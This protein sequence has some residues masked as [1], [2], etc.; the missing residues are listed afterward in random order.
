MG[1]VSLD[2][3]TAPVF[4]ARGAGGASGAVR[5]VAVG[6]SVPVVVQKVGA[7]AFSNPGRGA[8]LVAAHHQGYC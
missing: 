7:G 1:V 5:V 3:I 4:P 2:Q 6:P 8:V